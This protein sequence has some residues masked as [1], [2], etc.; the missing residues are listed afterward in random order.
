MREDIHI[1]HDINVYALDRIS[2]SVT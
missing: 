2:G 1:F